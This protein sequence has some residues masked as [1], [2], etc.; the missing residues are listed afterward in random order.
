MVVVV[1]RTRRG[2][3]GVPAMLGVVA[4]TRARRGERNF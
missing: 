4:L 2:F 1:V 3:A